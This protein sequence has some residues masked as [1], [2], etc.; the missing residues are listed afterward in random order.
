MNSLFSDNYS[1]FIEGVVAPSTPLR[2]HV[3]KRIFKLISEKYDD[4][5]QFTNDFYYQVGE[6]DLSDFSASLRPDWQKLLAPHFPYEN[7]DLY[8][9]AGEL[10]PVGTAIIMPLEVLLQAEI[11]SVLAQIELLHEEWMNHDFLEEIKLF[12]RNFSW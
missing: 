11:K 6:M 5:E 12:Y 4:D 2:K 8:D 9:E 3:F 10:T 7:N 1:T